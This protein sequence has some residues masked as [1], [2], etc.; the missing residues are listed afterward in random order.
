MILVSIM[1]IGAD[2]AKIP[3]AIVYLVS[4]LGRKRSLT[5]WYPTAPLLVSLANPKQNLFFLQLFFQF[6]HEHGL[7][8][9]IQ[10]RILP[11][12]RSGVEPRLL[13]L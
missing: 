1:Q 3:A 5:P 13:F 2:I 4:L 7:L 10:L 8:A 12:W 6:L 11:F 9:D